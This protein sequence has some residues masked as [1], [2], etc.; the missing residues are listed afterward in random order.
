MKIEKID[1]FKII[2]I[3]ESKNSS[4]KVIIQNKTLNNSTKLNGKTLEAQFSFK[5]NFLIKR[6]KSFLL[7]NWLTLNQE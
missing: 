5:N 3:M 7:K 2:K 1:N 4:P 6:K